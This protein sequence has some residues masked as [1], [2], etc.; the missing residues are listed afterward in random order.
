[1]LA[2]SDKA[3]LAGAV[4][5]VVI[6]ALVLNRSMKG[7]FRG[8]KLQLGSQLESVDKAVNQ[9][10]KGSPTISQD[11]AEIRSTTTALHELVAEGVL[12][13]LDTVERT[14]RDLINRVSVLEHPPR[15]PDPPIPTPPHPDTEAPR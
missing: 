8:M 7:E 11:V 10:E 6:V 12:P 5:A 9:R 2:I 3:F 13:R 15:L 14:V 1:M 4:A